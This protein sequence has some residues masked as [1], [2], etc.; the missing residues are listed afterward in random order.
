MMATPNVDRKD[1]KL[2]IYDLESSFSL[3]AIFILF[4]LTMWARDFPTA[5]Q[6]WYV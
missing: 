1:S 3:L 5:F 2:L 4:S 6:P